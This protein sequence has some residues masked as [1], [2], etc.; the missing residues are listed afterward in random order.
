MEES[1]K[2]IFVHQVSNQHIFL[3]TQPFSKPRLPLNSAYEDLSKACQ[4]FANGHG[5]KLTKVEEQLR[6]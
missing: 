2:N 6:F 1:C 5:R 3:I 4:D